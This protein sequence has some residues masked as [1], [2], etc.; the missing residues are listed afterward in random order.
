MRFLSHILLIFIWCTALPVWATEGS[1]PTHSGSGGGDST[2][3]AS[4]EGNG[5]GSD[6]SETEKEATDA[7]GKL[8]KSDALK[9]T[10]GKSAE[11]ISK[12]ADEDSSNMTEFIG[13][14]KGEDGKFNEEFAAA[15]TGALSNLQQELTAQL[16]SLPVTPET[17]QQRTEIQAQLGRIA[18]LQGFISNNAPPGSAFAQGPSVLGGPIVGTTPPGGTGTGTNNNALDVAGQ[19]GGTSDPGSAASSASLASNQ[20]ATSQPLQ[21][22]PLPSITPTALPQQVAQQS[23]TPTTPQSAQAA[24][25]TQASA[26]P[27]TIYTAAV[28]KAT[29]AIQA[30]ETS[31][32]GPKE[33]AKSESSTKAETAP[34]QSAKEGVVTARESTKQRPSAETPK[35]F[36]PALLT[37]SAAGVS[38]NT[39]SAKTSEA[40]ST[41][42]AANENFD[43]NKINSAPPA[44]LSA[45]T[46]P[47]ASEIPRGLTTI[48][49][50]F[51]E[52]QTSTPAPVK[53][54]SEVASTE[55]T[56]E[57]R[58]S[59]VVSLR[60]V[61]SSRGLK[62]FENE[63]KKGLETLRERLSADG[64]SE[65][66]AERRELT[67]TNPAT[68]PTATEN[69]LVRTPSSGE[70]KPGGSVLQ[71]MNLMKQKAQENPA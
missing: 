31:F 37:T 15:A 33:P 42:I 21:S 67:S 44:V 28:E 17:Q 14:I 35:S 58:S 56:R 4:G 7:I 68:K 48:E 46:R 12:A 1:A 32:F 36:T 70:A 59:D 3:S 39:S 20:A 2:A 47:F 52:P 51:F 6:Q 24:S 41:A 40:S 45:G 49:Q 29:Q 8:V 13:K 11:D 54:S 22:L 65:P 66:N 26:K 38:P 23:V 18:A 61:A 25:P 63:M 27:P 30:L 57:Q 9:S 5:D 50:D 10:A 64:E 55:E 71:F 62:E 34:S 60:S 53:A 69:Q 16:N 19:S 43:F